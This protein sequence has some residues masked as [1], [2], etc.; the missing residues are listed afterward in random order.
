KGSLERTLEQCRDQQGGDGHL[1]PLD[2]ESFIAAASEAAGR[3]YRVLAMAGGPAPEGA[4]EITHDMLRGKLTFLGLQAML[5]PPRAEAIEAVAKCQG[6]GIEVKMITGD[7]ARTAA[8]IA[9]MIG[10]RA[11]A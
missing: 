10:L 1:A 8:S 6:A 5:D 2:P 3:G 11:Q 9:A 4:T 7:H